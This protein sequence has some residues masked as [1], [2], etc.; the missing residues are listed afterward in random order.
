MCARS[1]HGPPAQGTDTYGGRGRA[2]AARDRGHGAVGRA[3]VALLVVV[4]LLGGVAAWRLDLVG[5]LTDDDASSPTTSG[6]AAVPPPDELELPPL[7]DP[8]PVDST[9][10]PPGLIDP[11]LVQAAVAPYLSDPVLGKHVTGAVVD[12]GSGSP[13]V[14]L[15]GG[16]PAMPASTTKLLTTTAALSVL[17]P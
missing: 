1:A 3:V 6:P 2:V 17:G 15:G 10:S 13:V 8:S 9:L 11:A 16:G 5:R 4:L 12:L 14:K 7:S